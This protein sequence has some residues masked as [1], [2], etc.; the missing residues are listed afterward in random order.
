[1]QDIYP[2][3]CGDCPLAL[4]DELEKR[5]STVRTDEQR[6]I[7]EQRREEMIKNSQYGWWCTLR[8]DDR[9]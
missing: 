6:A 1:M 2:A 8:L 7:W 5:I 4:L 9:Q 3:S